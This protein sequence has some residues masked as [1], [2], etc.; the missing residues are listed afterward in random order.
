[1][2]EISPTGRLVEHTPKWQYIPGEPR[3]LSG[4]P[5]NLQNLPRDADYSALERRILA[6]MGPDTC[7]LMASA[8]HDAN[9]DQT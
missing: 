5:A 4:P 3:T 1:M 6:H 7:A 2:P 9:E 8:L